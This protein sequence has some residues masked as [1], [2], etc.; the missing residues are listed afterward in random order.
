MLEGEEKDRLEE[1]DI[2]LEGE[3]I[4][5][6]KKPTRLQTFLAQFGQ[7]IFEWSCVYITT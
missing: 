2:S 5:E 6:K 7:F 4:K 3:K 1:E